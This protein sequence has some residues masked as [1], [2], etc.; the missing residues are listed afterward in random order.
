MARRNLRNIAQAVLYWSRPRR[1]CKPR[2][3]MPFFLLVTCHIARNEI[4]KG[5][6][7]S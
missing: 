6:W 4:V 3:L 1:R 7:L 2:T 5:R